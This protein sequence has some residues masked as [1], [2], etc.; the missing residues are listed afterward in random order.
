MNQYKIE[1]G[2]LDPRDIKPDQFEKL[3]EKMIAAKYAIM[4]IKNPKRAINDRM[5]Y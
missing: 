2:E 4:D 1:K 3:A 5:M